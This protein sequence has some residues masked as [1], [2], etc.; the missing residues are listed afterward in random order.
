MPS[1][2]GED[3]ASNRRRRAVHGLGDIWCRCRRDERSEWPSDCSRGDS[4]NTEYDLLNTV[5]S[6]V[7]GS[8]PAYMK[9][10]L[11]RVGMHASFY[12][13][14]DSTTGRAIGYVSGSAIGAE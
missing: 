3:G 12:R 2:D 7:T 13:F 10:M 9:A 11:D 6:R 1:L 5:I 14:R 4:R 8:H